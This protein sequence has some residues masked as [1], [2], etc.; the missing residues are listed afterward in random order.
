MG[1]TLLS[2]PAYAN[3]VREYSEAEKQEASDLIV[4]GTVTGFHEET[5]PSKVTGLT[6]DL[7]VHYAEV[8][9]KR[10]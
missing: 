4:V 10:M 3:Y 6:F 9:S 8:S 7:T 2:A 1:L 5:E